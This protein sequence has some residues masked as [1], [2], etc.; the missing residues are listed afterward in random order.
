MTTPPASRPA[1]LT[2]ACI[3]G[4]SLVV[5]SH[6]IPRARHGSTQAVCRAL[7]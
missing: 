6:L 3:A 5:P 7:L 1:A 4:V 2:A